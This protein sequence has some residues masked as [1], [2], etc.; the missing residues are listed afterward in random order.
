MEHSILHHPDMPASAYKELWDVV[1]AGMI[2][3]G[4]VKNLRKD[5]AFYWVYATVIPNVRY[6]EVV[7]YTSVRRKPSRSKVDAAARL[8][9]QLLATEKTR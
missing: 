9:Q 2:W 6:S 1:R 8:Y 7:G 5:G 4:H 3:R